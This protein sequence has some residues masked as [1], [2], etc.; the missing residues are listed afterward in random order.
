MILNAVPNKSRAYM[1]WKW[2][3][4]DNQ[5]EYNAK[6]KPIVQRIRRLEKIELMVEQSQIL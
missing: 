2:R 4:K 6:S 3:T 5:K 1:K